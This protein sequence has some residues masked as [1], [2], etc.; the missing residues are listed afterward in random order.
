VQKAFGERWQE[1]GE[2]RAKADPENRL[3]DSYFRE[4]LS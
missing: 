3:L 1:F 4:L 2:A